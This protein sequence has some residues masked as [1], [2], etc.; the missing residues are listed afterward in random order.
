MGPLALGHQPWD[1][2][3]AEVQEAQATSPEAPRLPGSP[4]SECLAS[5]VKL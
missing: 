3:H 2:L 4:S 1:S 5:C